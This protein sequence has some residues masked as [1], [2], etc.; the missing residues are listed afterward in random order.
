MFL[1]AERMN[2]NDEESREEVDK[3]KIDRTL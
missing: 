3:E 2:C 1:Y